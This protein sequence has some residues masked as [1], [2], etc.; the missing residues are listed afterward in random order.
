MFNSLR[1]LEFFVIVVIKD[2]IGEAGQYKVYWLNNS[3]VS[4]S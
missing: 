1:N 4:A 3:V 2:I